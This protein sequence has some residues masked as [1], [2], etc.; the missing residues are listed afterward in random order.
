MNV[1][2][3]E[4]L[5]SNVCAYNIYVMVRFNSVSCTYNMPLY[6]GYALDM[7]IVE[8]RLYARLYRIHLLLLE[9]VF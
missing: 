6:E 8:V 2:W 9:L 5:A 7:L 3:H 4:N 1:S